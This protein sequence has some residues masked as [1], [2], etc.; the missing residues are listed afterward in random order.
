[1]PM[2]LLLLGIMF[3]TAAVRGKDKV[4]LLFST[5]KDDFTGPNNFFEWGVALF[6]IGAVGYYKPLKPVS[7]AFMTLLIVVLFLSNKGF[8]NEFM[9]QVKGTETTYSPSVDGRN[10]PENPNNLMGNVTSL[11]SKAMQGFGLGAL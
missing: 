9:S 7:T 4:D 2:F 5:I 10:S 6:V 3:L 1:M 8:F 11:V